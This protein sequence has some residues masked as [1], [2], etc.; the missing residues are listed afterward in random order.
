MVPK[1]SLRW[2]SPECHSPLSPPNL[3]Y[4]AFKVQFKP[5][6]FVKLFTK[7]FI[8]SALTPP[9][10]FIWLLICITLCLT[11]WISVFLKVYLNYFS[12][13]KDTVLIFFFFNRPQNPAPSRH[14]MSD[15]SETSPWDIT[16]LVTYISS[17]LFLNSFKKFY[18]Y[19][20]N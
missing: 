10:P 18:I 11:S 15:G 16:S 6:S 2:H 7:L 4:G 17:Y 5:C 12:E 13:N 14:Q 1:F 8:W 19:I 3:L 20:Y 9:A